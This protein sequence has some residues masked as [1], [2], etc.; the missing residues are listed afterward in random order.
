ME[1]MKTTAELVKEEING[2]LF[3]KES[4]K[5]DL[6]NYS[7]LVRLL[8]ARIKR[9][10]PKANFASILIAIQRYQD[11]LAKKHSNLQSLKK[12]LSSSEIIMKNKIASLT[13]AR[14]GEAMKSLN[15]ISKNISWDR[16]DIF[17]TVQGSGEVTVIIDEKNEH[18]FEK[19]KETSILEEEKNLALISLRESDSQK[20]YSKESLGY[21]SLLTTTLADNGINILDIASTYRQVFFI[22]NEKD[23]TKTYNVFSKLI[24]SYK[25]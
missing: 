11:E 17:F 24:E 21:L 8:L 15:E 6:I 2:S 3:I 13:L 12:I 9:E 18:K 4:L 16:G 5:N 7:S 22:I 25:K 10:N 23:L 14:T 1:S 19:V 20:E